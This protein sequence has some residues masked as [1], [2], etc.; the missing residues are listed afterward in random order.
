MVFQKARKIQVLFALLLL[1]CSCSPRSFSAGSHS[2][3]ASVSGDGITGP[4]LDV[5]TEEESYLLKAQRV[6][7]DFLSENQTPYRLGLFDVNEDGTPEVMVQNFIG[8]A[9]KCILY[10]LISS[11]SIQLNWP[12]TSVDAVYIQRSEA[13]IKWR[14]EGDDSHGFTDRTRNEI[15]E[16]ENGEVKTVDCEL[17]CILGNDKEPYSLS[18]RTVIN[19]EEMESLNF[20]LE[21]IPAS[22]MDELLAGSLYQS[23]VQ[24]DWEELDSLPWVQ[25][26]ATATGSDQLQARIS[27]LYREWLSAH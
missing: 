10:D 8:Q 3:P 13:G 21:D 25:E 23:Y 16:I 17:T 14:I 24:Q 2:Q 20:S 15:L 12:A 22:E 27:K 4:A 6:V 9:S 7:E 18:V 1:L 5:S 11:G 26:E 19:G